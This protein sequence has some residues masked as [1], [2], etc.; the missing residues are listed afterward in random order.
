MTVPIPFY[1][2]AQFVVCAQ[3]HKVLVSS[4]SEAMG[5]GCNLSRE[6]I[7]QA[8]AL[9]NFNYCQRHIRRVIGCNKGALQKHVKKI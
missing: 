3:P 7:A 9:D 4:T 8:V 2:I 5:I 6:K 1:Y